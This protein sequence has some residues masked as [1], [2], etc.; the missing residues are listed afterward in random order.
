MSDPLAG[1]RFGLEALK[2]TVELR[3]AL[4]KAYADFNYRMMEVAEKQV[5]VTSDLVRL[6]QLRE[7]LRSYQR[8]RH[9]AER[10]LSRVRNEAEKWRRNIQLA[11]YL[12]LGE[13]LDP[14]QVSPAWRAYQFLIAKNPFDAKLKLAQIKAAAR[15][16]VGTNFSR[17]RSPGQACPDAPA[18]ITSAVALMDWARK[19]ILI[20][21]IQSAA[22][23]LLGKMMS[24]IN[25][26]ASASAA[27]LA[28][29]MNAAQSD[30][31]RIREMGWRAVDITKEFPK[32]P[33]DDSRS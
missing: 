31:A 10:E 17:N 21:R 9:D 19:G 2:L 33:P 16:R 15:H 5:K 14:D 13:I 24:V 8:A 25:D 22:Q 6:A 23:E 7:A 20:P 26:S 32:T 11:S 18:S 4:M 29:D 1:P 3:I 12:A 27:E 30:L 28:R